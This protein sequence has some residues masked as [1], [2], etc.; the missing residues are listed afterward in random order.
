MQVRINELLNYA[1]GYKIPLFMHGVDSIVE[2][3]LIDIKKHFIGSFLSFLRKFKVFNRMFHYYKSGERGIPVKLLSD[4]V[5][6]YEKITHKDS[7]ELLERISVINSGLSSIAHRSIKIEK[8]KT[9]G[10]LYN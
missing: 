7:V 3:I 1:V 10:F 4:L 9:I 5:K 2:E 6:E 8:F